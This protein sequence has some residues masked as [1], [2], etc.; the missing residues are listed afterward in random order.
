MFHKY[1]KIMSFPLIFQAHET[2]NRHFFPA[3]GRAL[4]T[5]NKSNDYS[6]MPDHKAVINETT[7][8]ALSIVRSSFL[9]VPHS[10]A[11]NIGCK[12]FEELFGTSP[13]IGSQRSS[14]SGISYTVELI[15]ETVRVRINRHGFKMEGVENWQEFIPFNKN[16]NTE[17]VFD[18]RGIIRPLLEQNTRNSVDN[19]SPEETE[20]LKRDLVPHHFEDFYHPFVRVHNHLRDQVGFTI[21]MGYYRSRCSNGVMF[22]SRNAMTF[23]TN[24]HSVKTVI[25]LEQEALHYFLHRK[26]SMFNVIGD[27]YKILSIPVA[28]ADMHLIT[29]SVFKEKLLAMDKQSRR[30]EYDLILDISARYASE[31]GCNMNAAMNVATEYAQRLY[32]N[33]R[34]ISGIQKMPS[35]L[36]RKMGSGG[37]RSASMLRRI[38]SE[39]QYILNHEGIHNVES[40]MED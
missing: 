24:Y 33:G 6:V 28:K 29:L 40:W 32:G 2:A 1:Q 34:V 9:I 22:G 17:F 14:H 37:I 31:I 21:E 16:R 11:F 30:A 7:G 12:I 20:Q 3:N 5:L 36:L 15:S 19:I 27:L 8:E 38:R 13:M 26:S 4:F 23:K 35:M 10:Q 39:E 18:D 25:N